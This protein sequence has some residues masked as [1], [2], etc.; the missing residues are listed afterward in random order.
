[1]TYRNQKYRIL[2]N[3]ILDILFIILGYVLSSYLVS[4]NGLYFLSMSIQ[5]I[6]LLSLLIVVTHSLVFSLLGI[7]KIIWRYYAN[8]DVV[9]LLI[10]VSLNAIF[11][12]VFFI[13]VRTHVI[14]RV[15]LLAWLLIVI[16]MLGYRFIGD[17]VSNVSQNA[18]LRLKSNNKYD[19]TR[20]MIIGAGN[21][22]QLLIEDI[23]N[24]PS[25]GVKVLCILDDDKD[26]HNKTLRSIP[27]IGDTRLIITSAEEYNIDTI[28]IAVPS[29]SEERIR[30]IIKLCNQTSCKLKIINSYLDVIM[31]EL[32]NVTLR[33]VLLEDLLSREPVRINS[34][35]LGSYLTHQTILV[36]GAG[37]SIGSELCRQIA[38][39]TPKQLVMLDIY[40][41]NL[42]ELELELRKQF[43]HVNIAVLIASVRDYNKLNQLFE[44]FRPNVVFHAA[45]HKHVP[46]METSPDE[47]VKNNVEGTLFTAKLSRAFGVSHFVLV[48]SDK[49][50]HP[51]SVMGATKRIGEMIIQSMDKASRTRFVAVRFGNVLGSSGSVVPI[52]KKQ[53]EAGGPVTV[54]HPDVTRYFMTI[55]ESVSLILQA[56]AYAEQGEIYVLDM[57]EPVKIVDLARKMIRLSGNVPNQD[58]DIVFT[59]LRPGEKLF[60]EMLLN[61]EGL[62]RTPNQRIYIASPIAFDRVKFQE[63]LDNLIEAAKTHNEQLREQ[64]W[65]ILD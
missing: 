25:F 17:K 33:N 53:I 63:D 50:V 31:S 4:S 30:E 9:T 47:A 60:E 3:L 27:I 40:E 56:G 11:T 5:D 52:F 44:K 37:G 22:G 6:I 24:N 54:T 36:T 14:L 15:H 35:E 49:A 41:N 8:Q 55:P 48:S 45:A 16:F 51:S 26:L 38:S 20:V 19:E 12:S 18:R 1:M 62:K 23:Q 61:E 59:G 34:L 21:T 10:G 65:H 13:I 46:L 43:P 64:I 57:G 32:S 7:Y 2:S 42:Y 28:I 39:Y 58:I 29:A